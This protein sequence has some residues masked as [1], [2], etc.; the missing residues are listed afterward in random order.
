MHR[1]SRLARRAILALPL[2][3]ASAAAT[4]SVWVAGNKHTFVVDPTL[5]RVV[6]LALD[7]PLA[8]APTDEDSAWLV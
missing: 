2:L 8:I 6:T 4:P 3:F 1:P 5:G 7:T